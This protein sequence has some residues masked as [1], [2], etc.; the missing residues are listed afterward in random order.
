[1]LV[2]EYQAKQILGNFGVPVPRGILA[3]TP[4]K[5]RT[6]AE[7][8]GGS[9]WV[10][11]AQVHAGGRG[12]GGGVRVCRSLD[13]VR[14]AA[15]VLLD[16]WFR[17][18]TPQTGL[19]GR[20]IRKVYVEEGLSIQRELYLGMVLD[21]DSQSIVVMG[22]TEG[23]VD[24]EEVAARTPD[25]ILKE[26]V[27][28]SV[29]L[30]PFQMRN[31]CK[32]LGLT[33]DLGRRARALMG[34]LYAVFVEKDASLLE[35]NPLIVT[36]NGQLWALDAKLNFDDNALFRHTDI[37]EL[38]DPDEVDPAEQRAYERDLSYVKL[39][40]TIGNMVNG[41]GLAMATM[42]IIA[43][44]GGAPANFLD[45]GGSASK[46][47]VKAAFQII[48]NDDVKAILVNI[49]GGITRC[50]VI[51]TGIL[52]AARE[53]ELK[54]PLVVRMQGTNSEEGRKILAESGLAIRTAE[55]MA[56]AAQKVVAASRG[57]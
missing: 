8:L 12:K 49:F 22:S 24:I 6:A 43:H 57:E 11:K 44:Y 38:R 40:G 54:V 5:A 34:A 45:V 7:R 56:E 19:E 32:G 35:I 48:Q 50:D 27:D 14:T 37:A 46:E 1:M 33:D 26:Y 3:M 13:E 51:A 39:D 4:D 47:K 36:D 28:F 18:V 16:P 29:G 20:R 25:K 10:V 2:H 21:R 17:L 55:T 42:D 31:L 9:V 15:A 30:Q 41:A 52:A 53:L 23:G